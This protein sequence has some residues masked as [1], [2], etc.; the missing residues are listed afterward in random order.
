[1]AGNSGRGAY[2]WTRMKVLLIE[3]DRTLADYVAKG[4]RECGHVV[5]VCRDGK[6]SHPG[7]ER[8]GHPL[9]FGPNPARLLEICHTGP[10]RPAPVWLARVVGRSDRPPPPGDPRAGVVF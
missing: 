3:D 2:Q 5:D 6:A 1:M 8:S 10:W 4:L 9:D 7:S